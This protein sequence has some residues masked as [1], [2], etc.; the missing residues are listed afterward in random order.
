MMVKCCPN[1]DGLKGQMMKALLSLWCVYAAVASFPLVAQIDH[2]DMAADC[3]KIASYAELGNTAYQQGNYR[4]SADIFRDQAA[5]SE[6]CGLSAQATATAYNN[7][8]LSL[9]HAGE[10]LKARAYL[11]LAP[12]D[13][14]SQYNMQLLQQRLDQVPA[15]SGPAGV[16]WQYAGRGIWSELHVKPQDQGWQVDFSG[17]YMPRMGLYY[18]PNMGSFSAELAIDQGKAVYQQHQAPLHCDV[19]MTFSSDVVDLHTEGDCGF[20]ANVR[21]AG[22]FVRVE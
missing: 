19:T 15:P 17:Y 10:L 7:V 4:K 22:R 16:Y 5:W 11:A 1:D 6:F 21:A 2:P 8:A 3:R 14:K 9:M 13:S 20:G 12:N 18:G